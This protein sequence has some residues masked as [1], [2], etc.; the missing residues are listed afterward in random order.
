MS[1][2]AKCF[3]TPKLYTTN[4]PFSGLALIAAKKI[5]PP[6]HVTQFLEGHIPPLKRGGG[7]NYV[8]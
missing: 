7:S 4:P 5:V 3:N 8:M 1:Q 2:W 6:P